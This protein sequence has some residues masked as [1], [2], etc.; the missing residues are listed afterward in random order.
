MEDVVNF[1]CFREGEAIS[2]MRILAA[3]LK[4]PYCL[5]DSLGVPSMCFRFIPSS[6]TLSPIW[7]SLYFWGCCL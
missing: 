3:T 5:G 1:P 7:N 6:H 2:D 4:G